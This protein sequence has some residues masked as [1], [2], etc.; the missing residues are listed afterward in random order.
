MLHI[1]ATIHVHVVDDKAMQAVQER[2]DL[3]LTHIHRVFTQGEQLMSAADDLKAGIAKIDSAT[4]NIAADIQRLKDKITSSMSPADVADVK[5]QLDAAVSR[6]E[7]IAADPDNPD[8]AASAPEPVPEPE[9]G[10]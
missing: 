1:N 6:L 10:A 3:L 2:L 5:A 7:G 4:N 8:P 9:P